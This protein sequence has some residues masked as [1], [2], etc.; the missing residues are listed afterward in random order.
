MFS[1]SVRLKALALLA[2]AGDWARGRL[3]E[4]AFR[5]VE[6]VAEDCPVD[7]RSRYLDVRVWYV[8][9]YA[10]EGKAG[11]IIPNALPGEAGFYVCYL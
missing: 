7:E 8:A 9:I 3:I 5:T 11:I 2:E 6:E 4:E 1:R 10:G